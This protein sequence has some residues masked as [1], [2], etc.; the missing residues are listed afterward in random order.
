M[1][2]LIKKD[3]V[4]ILLK[5]RTKYLSVVIVDNLDITEEKHKKLD[6]LYNKT[7]LFFVFK[8]SMLGKRIDY[9]KFS[10]L[11]RAIGFIVVRGTELEYP[12]EVLFK[13]LLYFQEV[14]NNAYLFYGITKIS[15]LDFDVASYINTSEAALMKQVNASIYNVTRYSADKLALYYT[16]EE[17]YTVEDK[18]LID[19]KLVKILNFA[20][21]LFPKLKF[22]KGFN[23]KE[24]EN[25][26]TPLWDA[27][28]THYSSSKILFIPKAILKTLLDYWMNKDNTNVI[29]SFYDEGNDFEVFASLADF[30][31]LQY[32][33]EDILD[34]K[35]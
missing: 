16:I 28:T 14:Y 9:K 8:E 23:H 4:Y 10:Y 33:N 25:S 29:R 17:E 6:D 2:E 24:K 31:K 15:K 30:L 20:N 32:V 35:I 27:Y 18:E 11:Y 7:D 3:E 26:Q 34:L 22:F 5:N 12:V 13:S 19:G 21:E 1:S